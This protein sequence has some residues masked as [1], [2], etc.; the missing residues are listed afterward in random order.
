MNLLDQTVVVDLEGLV[1]ALLWYDSIARE[2]HLAPR[3][4][5]M[6]YLRLWKGHVWNMEW[7]RD[8]LPVRGIGLV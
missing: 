2:P 4:A 1:S 8:S 7:P 3:N 6:L 5:I